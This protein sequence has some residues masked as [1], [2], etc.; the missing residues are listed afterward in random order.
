MLEIF[1]PNSTGASL[2][3]AD[4]VLRFAGSKNSRQQADTTGNA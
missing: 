4:I 3:R 2:L 1:Y